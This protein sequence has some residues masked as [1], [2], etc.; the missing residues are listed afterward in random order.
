MG[1]SLSTVTMIISMFDVYFKS[2]LPNL[3][4]SFLEIEKKEWCII[5]LLIAIVGLQ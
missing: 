2:L 3:F 5:M 4:C 1:L